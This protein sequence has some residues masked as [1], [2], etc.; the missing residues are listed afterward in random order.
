MKNKNIGAKI[1]VKRVITEISKENGW[2][3][4]KNVPAIIISKEGLEHYYPTSDGA[5]GNVR[6]HTIF[7]SYGDT[8]GVKLDNGLTDNFGNNKFI[9]REYEVKFLE[10]LPKVIKPVTKQAYQRALKVVERY[11][12]ENNL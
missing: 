6:K 5:H 3:I 8:I 9:V 12:K 11:K 10:T 2:V 7:N 1:L 4:T